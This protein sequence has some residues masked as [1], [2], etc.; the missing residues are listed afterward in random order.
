MLR[1]TTT[2]IRSLPATGPRRAYASRPHPL[3]TRVTPKGPIPAGKTPPHLKPKAQKFSPLTLVL[4]A[5]L[6]GSTTYALGRREGKSSESE[7][8]GKLSWK[9]PTREDFNRAVEDLKTYFPE[10]C[11]AEDKDSLIAHGWNDWGEPSIFE[12]S[13]L[14]SKLT[15]SNVSRTAAHGPTGLPGAIVYPRST[16]DVVKIVKTA[17][18]NSI[19]LI[20]YCAGTSLE[21]NSPLP[22]FRPNQT[23]YY[24][25]YPFHRSHERSRI[26]WICRC[27]P[28]RSFTNS[29]RRPKAW[30]RYRRRL[31]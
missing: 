28:R 27:S 12:F 21:G 20:P 4:L 24:V 19:P 18:A 22:L 15:G 6:T 23:H 3:A 29:S 8:V 13:T 1:S 10:D 2:P 31:R 11:V 30:T 7:Q 25:S 16:E 26:S 9:E 17:S 5:T 14:R